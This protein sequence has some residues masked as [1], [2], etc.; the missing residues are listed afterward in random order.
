MGIPSRGELELPG[1]LPP[2]PGRRRDAFLLLFLFVGVA[3]G[4]E[5][6]F[7]GSRPRGGGQ[8][9]PWGSA[10]VA[11]LREGLGAARAG[12]WSGRAGDAAAAAS[13]A[14]GSRPGV[15]QS[16]RQPRCCQGQGHGTAPRSPSE[17]PHH[18]AP[19][20]GNNPSPGT[21]TALNPSARSPMAGHDGAEPT[22]KSPQP[23]AQRH[24]HSPWP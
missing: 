21:L 1:F 5:S 3:E 6:S 24:C 15:E 10:L 8:R 23:H 2:A 7:S 11:L 16:R 17:L 22:P 4:E 18:H 9:W 19:P 13:R 12:G 20:R 14:P